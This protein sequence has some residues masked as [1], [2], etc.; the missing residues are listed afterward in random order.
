MEFHEDEWITLQGRSIEK[1][2]VR[3]RNSSRIHQKES[4][5]SF[6]HSSVSSGKRK[7]TTKTIGSKA[8]AII[9]PLTTNFHTIYK[10]SLFNNMIHSFR[11]ISHIKKLKIV[12]N[13]HECFPSI[14]KKTETC[15]DIALRVPPYIMCEHGKISRKNQNTTSIH[16][17]KTD[18]LW[19]NGTR[20]SPEFQFLPFFF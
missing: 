8:R 2:V 1:H 19:I 9:Q 11:L 18:H 20:S 15:E 3:L 14:Q 7:T 17:C 12:A 6:L 13:K 5:V 4:G 10:Q 16:L